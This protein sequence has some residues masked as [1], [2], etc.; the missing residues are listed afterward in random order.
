MLVEHLVFN[1]VVEQEDNL[2]IYY[3]YRNYGAGEQ[4]IEKT[5]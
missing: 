5:P 1:Q 2:L 4:Q 3:E